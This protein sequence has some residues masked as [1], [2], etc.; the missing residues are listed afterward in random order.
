MYIGTLCWKQ[1]KKGRISW[2]L[3]QQDEEEEEQQEDEED[4]QK[5]EQVD[6]SHLSRIFLQPVLSTLNRRLSYR[7][8][9]NAG[10]NSLRW[11]NQVTWC[12]CSW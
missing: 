10:N 11:T 9:L 2:F 12:T 5:E 4:E 3:Q 6:Y 8:S 1:I 7:V